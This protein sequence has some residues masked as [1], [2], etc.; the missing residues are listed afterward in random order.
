MARKQRETEPKT[1]RRQL[2]GMALVVA[3]GLTAPLWFPVYIWVA[4]GI[5]QVVGQRTVAAITEGQKKAAE[6]ARPRNR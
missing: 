4:G 5:G 6:T 1:L 3:L 2:L